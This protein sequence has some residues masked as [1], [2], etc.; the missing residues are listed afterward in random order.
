MY[1]L[2]DTYLPG[3]IVD[4]EEMESRQLLKKK[5]TDLIETAEIKQR[6]HQKEQAY[7][8]KV[9]KQDVKQLV[10]DVKEFRNNFEL[11]GPMVLGTS[12]KEASDRLKRFENEF[13]LKEAIYKV[14]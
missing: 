2:L 14:N 4:K 6:E 5:W 12:P 8:L 1:S 13:E 11:E 9:L 10:S 7:H 3:G